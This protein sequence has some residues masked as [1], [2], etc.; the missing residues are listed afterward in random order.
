MD[1]SENTQLLREIRPLVA[2]L[3]RRREWI[4]WC[5][6]LVSLTVG[7]SCSVYYLLHAWGSWQAA[8]A[9]VVGGLCLYRISMFMHE[10]VHFH[11]G[12]MRPFTI[13]WNLVV[14]IPMLLPSFFYEPH[15]EHHANRYGTEEDGEYLPLV[16]GGWWGVVIYLSEIVLLPVY[17]VLRFLI[18]TPLSFF[19][20]R[21]RDWILRRH[22]TFVIDLRYQREIKDDAP[23]TLWAWIE[24]GC[25]MRIL[26]LLTLIAI[27][28]APVTRIPKIFA[29]ACLA[30]G[31][32]HLRTLVA[33]RYASEGKRMSHSDQFLD[34][35]N[36]TGSWLTEFICPL[37][38]RIHALH[39]LLPG[40]PYHNLGRAHRLLRERCRPILRITK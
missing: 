34:S 32:N 31:L 33:H 39:H 10:I 15:R 28:M 26:T 30:L 8:A 9:F 5:D 29:L 19:S 22:S 7:Y 38:L 20:P 11:A 1:H 16:H 27:G 36:I 25:L 21:L 14:G 12:E 6:F 23:R 18:G 2:H 3:Y 24:V 40:L 17:F 13:V 37:G 4:Y 35:T